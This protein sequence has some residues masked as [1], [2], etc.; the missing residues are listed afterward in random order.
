MLRV[1]EFQEYEYSQSVNPNAVSI[2][3]IAK[4]FHTVIKGR[5]T[6]SLVTC[7]L[8]STAYRKCQEKFAFHN[9]MAKKPSEAIVD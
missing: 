6:E 2:G 7:W 8:L 1:M 4:S 9:G 3:E 5:E